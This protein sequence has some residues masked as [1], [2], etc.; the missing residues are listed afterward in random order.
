MVSHRLN[1][2]LGALEMEKG[3]LVEHD[4]VGNPN[5]EVAVRQDG[6]LSVCSH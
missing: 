6:D 3:H 2:G 1:G 5:T 4:P